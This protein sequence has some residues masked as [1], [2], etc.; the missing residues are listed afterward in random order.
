MQEFADYDHYWD[1]R[2]KLETVHLR[3]KLAADLIE[4]GSSVL[5]VGCGS[6]EFLTYL[7]SLEKPDMQLAGVDFSP[8]AVEMTRE[9]GFDAECVDLVEGSIS[10]TY[11]YVTCFE[12]LEHIAEAEVALQTLRGAFRKQLLVSVPNIG[13]LGCRLRLALFGRFPTTTCVMHIKE[14]IRHWTPKDFEEW[15]AHFGLRVVDALPQSPVFGTPWRRFP[16]L[17][18]AGLLYVLEHDES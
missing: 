2:G 4:P 5:D 3:W 12:V 8:R 18:S 6:G 1:Q 10:G 13:Y 17:F 11:D 16:G 9:V 14:H 15:V 7:A